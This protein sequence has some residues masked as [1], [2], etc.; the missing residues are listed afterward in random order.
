MNFV[1]FLKKKTFENKKNKT[2][3]NEK[4]SYLKNNEK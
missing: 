3:V 2:N 4:K 1:F